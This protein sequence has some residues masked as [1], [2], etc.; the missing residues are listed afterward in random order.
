MVKYTKY[1]LLVI[2]IV[3]VGY[4]F[5]DR[6]QGD[7]F[8]V[9]EGDH[10]AG[11]VAKRDFKLTVNLSYA[12]KKIGKGY[13]QSEVNLITDDKL[14]GVI[15]MTNMQE[16]SGKQPFLINIDNRS[17]NKKLYFYVFHADSR[18]RIRTLFPNKKG[19]LWNPVY[20]GSNYNMPYNK[21]W[22][23]FSNKK[24][25]EKF[26]FFVSKKKMRVFKRRP[27]KRML[28]SRIKRYNKAYIAVITE[29]KQVKDNK[30]NPVMVWF[31]N[32]YA[33]KVV[34]INKGKSNGTPKYLI[35]K[36]KRE[37]IKG[38]TKVIR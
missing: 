13:L 6:T 5:V 35:R 17:V 8:A 37:L 33:T 19:G 12:K 16:V 15:P 18:N 31:K 9:T 38:K 2:F 20:Q 25:V 30:V 7:E 11:H 26:Y 10:G 22:F 21:K 32:K 3:F 24:G 27:T 29:R 23:N 14:E 36:A 4:F 34:V 28:D 1:L